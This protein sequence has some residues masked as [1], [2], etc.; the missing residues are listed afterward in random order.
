MRVT[1]PVPVAMYMLL[2]ALL[3]PIAAFSAHRALS[4]DAVVRLV[5]A[6]GCA[7]AAIGILNDY[8]DRAL[9]AASKPQKPLVRG[10][11]GTG[12]PS[13]AGGGESGGPPR[14]TTCVRSPSPV[15]S[16]P[17]SPDSAGWTH[18]GAPA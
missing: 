15:T 14:G 18:D 17:F 11:V 7:Q 1:H 10:T 16:A 3:A 4:I 2:M 8:C 13:R 12:G 6:M 9:D 5:L